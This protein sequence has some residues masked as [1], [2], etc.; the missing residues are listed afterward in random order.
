[1]FCKRAA[2]RGVSVVLC[3]LNFKLAFNTSV[4]RSEF[5][6]VS[7]S[8]T[9]KNPSSP[10]TLRQF[11][12]LV[13]FPFFTLL[14]SAQVRRVM[15][16]ALKKHNNHLENLPAA[17]FSETATRRVNT[18]A[19]YMM[20]QLCQNYVQTWQTRVVF[21]ASVRFSCDKESLAMWNFTGQTTRGN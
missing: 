9:Q 18:K 7:G 4:S 21:S 1:M 12:K 13:L 5:F 15:L 10:V 20:L 2:G 19:F 8:H 14:S 11:R 16:Q 6:E 3:K 17:R